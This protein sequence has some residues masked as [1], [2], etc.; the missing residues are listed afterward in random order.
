MEMTVPE[1]VA[2]I[3]GFRDYAPE[4]LESYRREMGICHESGRYQARSGVL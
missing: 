3:E 4:Q 2:T 1:D